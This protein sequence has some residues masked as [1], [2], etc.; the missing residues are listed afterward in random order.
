MYVQSCCY[1][2]ETYCFLFFFLTFLL[3]SASLNLKVLNE[4][5]NTAVTYYRPL[6]LSVD[7][8]FLSRHHDEKIFSVNVKNASLGSVFFA[9]KFLR[10]LGSS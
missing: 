7:C 1:G 6:Y 9:V 8:I 10:L 3:P 2:Y 5:L 4:T